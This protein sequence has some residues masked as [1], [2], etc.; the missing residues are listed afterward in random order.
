VRALEEGLQPEREIERYRH[1][2]AAVKAVRDRFNEAVT[3]RQK[4]EIMKE[5]E[6]ASFDEMRI[7][8]RA[9]ND[10]RFII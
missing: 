9:S 3:P 2:A 10:A 7:F 4:L 1:Y 5:M 6:R 8:L